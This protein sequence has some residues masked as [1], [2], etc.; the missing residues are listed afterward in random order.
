M[1]VGAYIS[2]PPRQG[3]GLSSG[4]F[5]SDANAAS[6]PFADLRDGRGQIC[7]R[8]LRRCACRRI[9]QEAATLADWRASQLGLDLLGS[10]VHPVP[11]HGGSL[12]FE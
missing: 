11:H 3:A 8:S 1:P 4:A 7:Q 5:L 10:S 12:P 9:H 2:G 6:S